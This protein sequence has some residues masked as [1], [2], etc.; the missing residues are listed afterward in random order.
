MSSNFSK[1]APIFRG[2]FLRKVANGAHMPELAERLR[3]C[4]LDH[5]MILPLWEIFEEAH[6]V[7]VQYYRCEYI[8][9]NILTH[10]WFESEHAVEN[11]YITEE[12]RIG[13]SRVD[14]AVFANASFAFE[15]KT[16][17][18]SMARIGTQ[19]EDYL[20]VF[21]Y[22][23]VVTSLKLRDT[24]AKAIPKS[25]GM[26]TINSFGTLEAFRESESHGKFLDLKVFQGCLRQGEMVAMIEQSTGQKVDV[27]NSK[28]FTECRKRFKQMLPFEVQKLF[29]DQLRQRR[30]P[31]ANLKL[32]KDAPPSLKHASLTLTGTAQEIERLRINLTKV[33]PRPDAKNHAHILPL[34][35]RET[36]RA[37]RCP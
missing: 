3:S 23:Y 6:K 12:F 22:V 21:D 26:L 2:P 11:T 4:G 27:P 31:V 28:I 7:L 24:A 34:P 25:V 15:I 30:Y 13:R 8:F 33:W 16:D 19:T 32:L 1:L 14:L 36:E 37:H 17:Y 29:V 20:K 18:D 35:S 10:N 9:K 5:L